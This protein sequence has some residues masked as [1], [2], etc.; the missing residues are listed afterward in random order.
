M[1][2]IASETNGVNIHSEI[3]PWL[4]PLAYSLLSNLVLPIFFGRIQISGQERLPQSGAVILAPTHRSRWDPII[5][6]YAAGRLATGRDL[7]YMVLLEQT[8][9]IQGWFVRRLG[10]FPIDRTRPTTA[11]IR[12]SVELLQNQNVLVL[13]P[14]GHIIPDHKIDKIQPGVARIALQAVSDQSDLSVAIVPVSIYY[15]HPAPP[16]MGCKIWVNIGSPL[17]VRE[18]QQDS[19]KKATRHLTTDL[20]EGLQALHQPPSE[21]LL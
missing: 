15:Q 20:K 9:G 6:A 5:L 8:Q 7:R 4:T 18:Y 19:I 1:S 14:E 13:F 21:L 11:S 17:N 2:D 10:G 12:Y 3:S 16:P